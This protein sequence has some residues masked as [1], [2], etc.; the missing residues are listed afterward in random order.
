MSTTK[1]PISSV[2]SETEV[3]SEHL[4]TALNVSS[5]ISSVLST[6]STEQPQGPTQTTTFTDNATAKT[7]HTQ[8]DRIRSTTSSSPKGKSN[9]S[10]SS[11][12]SCRCQKRTVANTTENQEMQTLKVT[13]Y[14]WL[15]KCTL[16]PMI[17]SGMIKVSNCPY[18]CKCSP[19]GSSTNVQEDM[20]ACVR[21]P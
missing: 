5:H 17:D 10:Q 3:T 16:Q 9:C 20:F 12:N 7:T 11:T 19:K 21:R 4:S 15:N 2:E 6:T 13:D 8:T 18:V 1:E 14:I